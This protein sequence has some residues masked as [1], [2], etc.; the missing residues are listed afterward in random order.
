MDKFNF[1]VR[2]GTNVQYFDDPEDA[3]HFAV[4]MVE[5]HHWLKDVVVCVQRIPNMK[6]EE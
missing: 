4:F 5:E 3:I 2:W 1:T 6:E